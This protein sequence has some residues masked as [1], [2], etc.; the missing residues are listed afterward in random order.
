MSD[1]PWHFA[2]FGL[3]L[4]WAQYD[5][6]IPSRMRPLLVSSVSHIH[7][8]K[9]IRFMQRWTI[10]WWRAR[11]NASTLNLWVLRDMLVMTVAPNT[12]ESQN[13][14]EVLLL[15]GPAII[16]TFKN[17]LFRYIAEL[18]FTKLNTSISQVHLVDSG[19]LEPPFSKY[20]DGIWSQCKM[21]FAA[22]NCSWQF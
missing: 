11:K 22:S 2:F 12:N 5:F 13:L 20:L 18:R 16:F 6:V 21:F 14:K 1:K 15:K 4:F 17:V 9:D 19:F 10:W 7:L 8:F 3:L